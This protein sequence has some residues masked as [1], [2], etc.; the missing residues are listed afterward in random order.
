MAYSAEVSYIL[1]LISGVSLHTFLYRYGGWDAKSPTLALAYLLVMLTGT[2]GVHYSPSV[3][4]PWKGSLADFWRLFVYH[5]LGVYGSMLIYRALFHRLV[6][7]PGPFLARLSNL[8]ITRLV[9]KKLLLHEEIHELH[10]QFGDYVRLG[11]TD[12]FH[13]PPAQLTIHS[14]LLIGPRE[15]SITD[16]AAVTAIYGTRSDTTKGPWYTLLDPRTPMSFTRDKVEHARRRK[17]WD[18]SFNTKCNRPLTYFLHKY[19]TNVQ[20]STR[21]L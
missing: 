8:Y 5:L 1:A 21:C 3:Q 16:P 19:M 9:S 4:N 15:L 18:Q 17:V 12:L 14:S 20:N 6:Q 11:R 2:I 13:Y 7:F 10:A